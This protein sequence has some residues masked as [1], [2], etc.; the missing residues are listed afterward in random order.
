MN[1]GGANTCGF[2][3]QRSYG[4]VNAMTA[5]GPAGFRIKVECG[6]FTTAWP[7]ARLLASSRD[8]ELVEE[9]GKPKDSRLRRIISQF[10]LLQ[11]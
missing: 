6:V 7:C 10:G 2:G 1:T 4:I 11:L 9:V 3:N 5:D 8:E